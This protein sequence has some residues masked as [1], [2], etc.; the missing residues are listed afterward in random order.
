MER[1]QRYRAR[2]GGID[3]GAGDVQATEVRRLT[4]EDAAEQLLL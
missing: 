2:S 4:P 3:Q 1:E